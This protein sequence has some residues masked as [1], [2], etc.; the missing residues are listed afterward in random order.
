M[1]SREKADLDQ[2]RRQIA[3]LQKR[4]TELERKAPDGGLMCGDSGIVAKDRVVP[5]GT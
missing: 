3:R 5:Q 2:A 4:I 1:T